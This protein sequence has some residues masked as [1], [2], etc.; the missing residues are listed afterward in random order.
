MRT[1]A[2]T[3]GIGSGKSEVC[4]ILSKRGIPVYD[5]DSAAKKLYD[6]DVSLLDSIESAFK[7]KLKLSDGSL[8]RS[9]LASIV[10]ASPERLKTLENIIHPAV[11]NDFQNWNAIQDARFEEWDASD[12]FYGKRPFCVFES[13]IILGKPEFLSLVSKVVMVDAPLE[14]RVERASVR[15]NVP[16][17]RILKRINVQSFDLTKVDA[18]IHN[19]GAID[20]LG[21]ETE[22]V[23]RSLEF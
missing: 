18:V 16:Q 2:I 14:K 3:G 20:L 5:S 15:D 23:F 22:K 8:D 21:Q 9:K 6:E 11:L 10:F 7:V 13:A 4:S 17:D 19:D 1:V 12:V